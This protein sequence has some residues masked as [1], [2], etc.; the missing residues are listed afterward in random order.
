[1]IKIFEDMNESINQLTDAISQIS[2]K[3]GAMKE[4]ESDEDFRERLLMS[5]PRTRKTGLYIIQKN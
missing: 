3:L 2:D 1:M 5:D 4:G